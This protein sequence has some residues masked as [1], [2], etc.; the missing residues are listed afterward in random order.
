MV[1]EFSRSFVLK[2][3]LYCSDAEHPMLSMMQLQE[4]GGQLTFQ[5]T[6]CTLVLPDDCILYEKFIN[7]L[8]YLTNFS[9]EGKY[10]AMI[11]T[12][13]QAVQA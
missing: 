9:R 12:R 7:K 1:D 6:N 13:S 10:T 11:M 4:E 2:P 5:G 8:L 3:V